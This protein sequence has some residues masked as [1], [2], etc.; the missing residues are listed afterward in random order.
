MVLIDTE[1]SEKKATSSPKK[2]QK[3]NKSRV[4]VLIQPT[5]FPPKPFDCSGRFSCVQIFFKRGHNRQ[6]FMYVWSHI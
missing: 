1:Y 6:L 3:R 4:Y 2:K 5:M